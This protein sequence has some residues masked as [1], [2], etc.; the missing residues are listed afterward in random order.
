MGGLIYF[1]FLH[2]GSHKICKYAAPNPH[3]I[4][5]RQ[6]NEFSLFNDIL[7]MLIPALKSA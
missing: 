4:I 5:D 6:T 2:T 1:Y 3:I 7:I